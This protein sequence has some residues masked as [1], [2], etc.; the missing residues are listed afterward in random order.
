MPRKYSDYFEIDP[1]LL[2]EYGVLD[3]YTD[4]DSR[5][6]IDPSL[7]EQINVNEFKSAKLLFENKFREIRDQIVKSINI[8]DPEY[9][10]AEKLLIFRESNAIRLG[11]ANNN[12]GRGIGDKLAKSICKNIFDI[13]KTQNNTD[14]NMLKY[15]FIFQ[16]GFG[17]DFISDMTA[18]IIIEC[19]YQYTNNIIEKLK[20]DDKHI[21]VL[22]NGIKVLKMND[23]KLCFVPRDI[24]TNI[25]IVSS[26]FSVNDL[27]AHNAELRAR[28]NAKVVEALM[29][30][31][32]RSIKK[33]LYKS[34]LKTN[35]NDIQMIYD[36]LPKNSYDFDKDPSNL[37]KWQGIADNYNIDQIVKKIATSTLTIS[38]FILTIIN[39]I[40]IS[41]IGS[42]YLSYS[43]RMRRNHLSLIYLSIIEKVIGGL[44]LQ[45]QIS[46]K[47]KGSSPFIVDNGVE[48]IGVT[49]TDSSYKIN[50]TGRIKRLDDINNFIEKEKI[51]E[52]FFVFIKKSITDKDKNISKY[53][54]NKKY[55]K[56]KLLTINAIVEK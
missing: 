11:Y 31:Q 56:I 54:T 18:K 33:R 43:Y 51:K 32:R 15:I 9:V 3:G 47:P 53:I 23:E 1:I 14:S 52:L 12:Y 44:S 17:A 39:S 36:N 20:L 21:F 6:Y 42:F 55:N 38:E 5:F 10:K 22:E 4:I 29:K 34:L 49:V 45:N 28:V 37:M 13:L 26:F 16:E 24:L 46:I 25:P 19:F 41:D 48:L 27:L 40:S 7:L 30:P 2:K 35:Y 8:G 50:E